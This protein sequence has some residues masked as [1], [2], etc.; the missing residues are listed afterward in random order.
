MDK[1]ASTHLIAHHI[2]WSYFLLL[3]AV[4]DQVMKMTQEQID[5]LPDVTRQQVL[6]V[7][8]LLMRQGAK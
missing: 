3:A 4:L 6:Q 5:A 1:G 8:Q 2:K 7:K